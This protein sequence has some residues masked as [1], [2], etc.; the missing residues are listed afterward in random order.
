MDESVRCAVCHRGVTC[1]QCAVR[2][3]EIKPILIVNAKLDKQIAL[4]PRLANG[5]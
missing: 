1:C 4:V 2:L 5:L 3:K